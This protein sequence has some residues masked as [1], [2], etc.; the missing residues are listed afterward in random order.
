MINTQQ[1]ANVRYGLSLKS[2]APHKAIA[3]PTGLHARLQLDR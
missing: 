3:F 2:D 1:I